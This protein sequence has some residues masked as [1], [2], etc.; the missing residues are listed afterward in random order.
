MTRGNPSFRALIVDD[1]PPARAFLRRMLSEHPDIELAGECSNGAQALETL[2]ST[3]ANLVFLDIE[4]P[5]MDGLAFVEAMQ[6][7]DVPAIVFVTAHDRYAVRAFDLAAVDYLLKPFD[8][9]RLERALARAR[10][11][12]SERTA[13]ER[14]QQVLTLLAQF[15]ARSEHLERFAVRSQGRIVLLAADEVEW[16]AANGNYLLLH[17]GRQRHML[18]ETM[19]NI[20]RRLDPK[21]FVRIHRST[22]VRIDCIREIRRTGN[23]DEQL[24]VLKDGTELVLSRGLRERVSQALGAQI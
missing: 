24:I 14:A 3:R 13:D 1:E 21:K 23:E 7:R 15:Q 5:E 8:H 6:G 16:I 22:M 20:E 2:R 12:L 17:A 4:M 19:Q 11:S 9:E 18:R 10:S